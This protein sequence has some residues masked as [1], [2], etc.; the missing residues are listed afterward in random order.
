MARLI[1]ISASQKIISVYE[2][3]SNSLHIQIYALILYKRG[4]AIAEVVSRW[5]PTAAALGRKCQSLSS[6]KPL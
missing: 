4:R 1:P 3:A 5:L 2:N 6:L